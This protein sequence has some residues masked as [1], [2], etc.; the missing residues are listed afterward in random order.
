MASARSH[1]SNPTE[2][3]EATSATHP[4]EGENIMPE[5]S[6]HSQPPKEAPD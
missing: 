4:G 3:T 5:Q 2:A 6:P 1:L